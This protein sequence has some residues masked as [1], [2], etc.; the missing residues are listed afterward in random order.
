MKCPVCGAAELVNDTRDVPYTYKGEST[1]I[2]AVSGMYCPSCPEIVLAMDEA[3]RY[4]DAAGAF[5]QQVNAN[6]GH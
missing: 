1:L 3:D 2:P 6:L 4:G 5:H